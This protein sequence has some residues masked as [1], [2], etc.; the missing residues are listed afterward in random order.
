MT[1]PIPNSNATHRSGPGR[2]IAG[3]QVGVEI[4]AL[5]AAQALG[6]PTGGT[7]PKGFRTEAGLCPHYAAEYGLQETAFS[8]LPASLRANI[9]TADL[10]LMIYT[11]KKGPNT[12][13][14]R[15][16]IEEI[17]KPAMTFGKIMP[18]RL[19]PFQWA[20]DVEAEFAPFIN[21]TGGFLA[22]PFAQSV[23]SY[24]LHVT[25]TRDPHLEAPVESWLRS[26][27]AAVLQAD[28]SVTSKEA[29]HA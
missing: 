7:M 11:D 3:G 6:I 25:G 5:R 29:N 18:P 14:A 20:I 24:T 22:T 10:T 21:V 2:I 12:R 4:A 16:I 8:Y 27:F 17:G 15:D 23:P 28:S 13:M 1:S 19:D 9:E 26:V